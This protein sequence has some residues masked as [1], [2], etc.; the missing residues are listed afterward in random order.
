MPNPEVERLTKESKKGQTQA[1][2]SA[3]IANEIRRG[4]DQQQAIAMCM[5]MAREKGASVPAPKG[6]S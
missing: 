3:C 1:A 6:G 4:R 2:I 5:G